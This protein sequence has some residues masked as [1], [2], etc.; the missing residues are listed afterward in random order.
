[1]KT[2]TVSLSL[3]ILCL[4]LVAVSA[5]AQTIY[6]NGP[7]NGQVTG[8]PINFGF[9]VTDSYYQ[10]RGILI[11]SGFSFWA[12]LFPDSIISQVEVSIGSAPYGTDLFHGVVGLRQSNCF[13][14]NDG[15]D[16]CLE[17]AE[18]P[19]VP[20]VNGRAWLTLQNANV[21]PFGDPVY[22]DQNSGVGCMSSG[23]PSKALE[24]GL[25]PVALIPSEAFTID[26]L[27]SASA[28]APGT[29]R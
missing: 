17:Y 27:M 9:A 26:G 7:V 3:L 18:F 8:W 19:G 13:T 14:N 22:W 11:F 5:M 16:V 12:W 4:T 28:P 21:L 1:L 10:E 24:N 15:Y 25:N 23:C 2:H 20:N 6:E 29:L